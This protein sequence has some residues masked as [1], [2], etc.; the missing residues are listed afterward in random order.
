[1]FSSTNNETELEHQNMA[2]DQTWVFNRQ[3][4]V[5]LPQQNLDLPLQMELQPGEMERQW[6]YDPG[7][8]KLLR[9]LSILQKRKFA[10]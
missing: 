8:A 4:S 3:K 1:M 7:I 5:S 9:I 10:R 6:S 2:I